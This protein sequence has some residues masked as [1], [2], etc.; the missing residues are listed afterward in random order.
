[1]HDILHDLWINAKPIQVFKAVST[2]KGL[3]SWWTLDSEGLPEENNTYRF[4][5]G[6]DYDWKGKVIDVDAPEAITWRMEQCD[7]DWDET[8]VG[9]NIIQKGSQS[10]VQFSHRGWPEKN[11]H[12]RRSSYCWATYLRLLKRY[13]EHGEFV[14]YE[15]RNS[16]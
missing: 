10:H 16:I 6:P 12:F 13:I 2:S 15:H 4:Y 5:F 9:F 14:P 7:K 8:E 3:N 1:M 11:E